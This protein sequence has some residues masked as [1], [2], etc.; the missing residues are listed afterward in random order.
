M[1]L[2]SRETLAASVPPAKEV[3]LFP[4]TPSML[5][6]RPAP[7]PTPLPEPVPIPPTE[8][9]PLPG[10]LL[11]FALGDGAGGGGGLGQTGLR[12]VNVVEIWLLSRSARDS[13]EV[14]FTVSVAALNN[15]GD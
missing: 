11:G 10:L 8:P 15:E 13:L 1:D 2:V 3:C 9:E 6:P 7:G 4:A 14:T 12:G 5:T